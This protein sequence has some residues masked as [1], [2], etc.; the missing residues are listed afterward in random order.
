MKLVQLTTVLI[1]TSLIGYGQKTI[2]ALGIFNNETERTEVRIDNVKRHTEVLTNYSSSTKQSLDSLIVQN[3]VQSTGHWAAEA[4]EI[5]TYDDK[6]NIIFYGQYFSTTG[7]KISYVYD[8]NNNLIQR[9]TLRKDDNT[10]YWSNFK[11]E[12]NFYNSNNKITETQELQWNTDQWLPYY[13]YENI[14]DSVGN[15]IQSTTYS[16]DV[17][18]SAWQHYRKYDFVYNIYGEN[19][20]EVYFNWDKNLNQWVALSKKEYT[21]D[22]NKN[23]IQN[24]YYNYSSS[25]GFAPLYKSQSSYNASNNLIQRMDSRW[26]DTESNWINQSKTEYVY[27]SNGNQTQYISYDWNISLSLWVEDMKVV[28]SFNNTFSNADLIIPSFYDGDN[29]LFNHMVTSYTLYN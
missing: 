7:S 8:S 6:E 24:I 10:N 26:N 1:L 25:T 13:K 3:W 29:S 9:V 27:D 23:L 4:K 19:I 15:K 16:W 28:Y 2:N 20:E 14:Y 5:Y 18:T 11:K 22:E 21:Y 12:L 17:D